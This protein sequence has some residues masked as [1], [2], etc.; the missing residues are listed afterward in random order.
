MDIMSN[1]RPPDLSVPP[2]ASPSHAGPGGGRSQADLDSHQI[3]PLTR[4]AQLFLIPDG[5]DPTLQRFILEKIS[6]HIAVFPYISLPDQ[7]T[8]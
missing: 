2:V 4:R 3:G 5:G 7:E 8:H 6:F 1:P